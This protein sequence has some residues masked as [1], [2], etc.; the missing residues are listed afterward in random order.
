MAYIVVAYI[1]MAYIVMACIV[2]AYIDMP[3]IAMAHKVH[4]WNVRAMA[5]KPS[6]RH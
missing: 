3:L 2:M 6:P 4:M 1:V 5:S